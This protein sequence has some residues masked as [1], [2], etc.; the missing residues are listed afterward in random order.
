MLLCHYI[1]MIVVVKACAEIMHIYIYT[2]TYIHIHIYIYIHVCM[3][4]YIYIYIYVRMYVYVCVCI[5][6]HLYI[7]IYIHTYMHTYIHTY[8]HIYIYI[9]ICV[10][11]SLVFHRCFVYFQ[12]LVL[13]SMCLVVLL[14]VFLCA[15]CLFTPCCCLLQLLFI[16]T[17][18]PVL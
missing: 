2:H 11:S 8:I 14:H 13:M 12:V 16:S 17:C 15:V 18:R 3:Y 4:V 7:Y 10:A 5:Y 6:T 9:Y 1:N